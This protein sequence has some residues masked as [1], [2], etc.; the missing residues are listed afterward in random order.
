[1]LEEVG[2][3]VAIRRQEPGEDD[4]EHRTGLA[5]VP[6]RRLRRRDRGQSRRQRRVHPPG[7][8]GQFVAGRLL[9]GEQVVQRPPGRGI[10]GSRGE[11]EIPEQDRRG[12]VVSRVLPVLPH[13]LGPLWGW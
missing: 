10:E 3:E 2:V 4:V 9:C 13:R 1:M 8:V 12:V 11:V 7:G 6:K 5:G